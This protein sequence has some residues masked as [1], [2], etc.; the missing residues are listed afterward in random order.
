MKNTKNL[1]LGLLV[2]FLFGVS[3][4][5]QVPPTLV[6]PV[7]SDLC[8]SKVVDFD[9]SE[10]PNAVTYNLEVADN[11]QFNNLI[12]N[13]TGLTVTDTT[14][15]LP[16]WMQ[17]YYWR[18]TSVFPDNNKG[19]AN[20]WSFKTKRPPL[21]LLSP[22]NGVFCADS[23]VVFAWDRADAEF[24]TLQVSESPDF[25]TLVF[26]K[27]NII[28]TFFSVSLP[29]YSTTYYWKVAH[30]KGVCQ[31]NFSEVWHLITKL[32]PPALL[33]PVNNAMGGGLL[34]GLPFNV[35]L[36]WQKS[37]MDMHYDVQLSSFQNF[38]DTL[39]EATNILD[40]NFALTLPEDFN[41]SYYWRVRVKENDCYSYWS[42]PYTLKT[43]YSMVELVL[44]AAA[45][46]CVTMQNTLFKW[47]AKPEVAR[48][49]LQV[50]NT[51]TFDSLLIDTSSINGNEINLN[52]ELAVQTHY[53]RVRGDDNQNIGM[54]SDVNMF[55][56]TLRPPNIISPVNG[57]NGL[58]KN[59][60]FKWENFGSNATY[61]LKVYQE[62]SP[63]NYTVILDTLGLSINEFDFFVPN[64]NT[65]YR[66]QVRGFAGGCTGDWTIMNEF[67]TLIPSPFLLLP[68][69]KSVKTALNPIFKWSAVVDADNYDIEISTD[70]TFQ[71]KFLTDNHIE[72]LIW[73][74]AGT[75]Y[76]EKTKYFW[77]VR[78]RN[79]D[80]V[81]LWSVPFSF[82]TD[83]LPAAAPV[84]LEPANGAI[85][86]VL[87][88]TFKW[89]T[90]QRAV[91]YIL[92]VSTDNKFENIFITQETE[93]TELE[94]VG[95]DRY[96]NYWWKVQAIGA[97]N[98]G[99]ISEV[100]TFRTKDIAPDKSV[101]LVSPA[102]NATNLSLIVDF[103]WEE[104]ERALAY[105]LEI[106]KNSDFSAGSIVQTHPTVM[107]L[108]RIVSE[109]EY[110]TTYYWRVAAW[111]EDGQAGWSAVRQ[112]KTL[113]NTSVS[114]NDVNVNSHVVFPN[115]TSSIAN[116][117]INATSL[118]VGNMRILNLLGIEMKKVENVELNVGENIINVD[119]SNLPSGVYIYSIETS[120]GNTTGRLVIR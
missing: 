28:D 101:V 98:P 68:E 71:T 81:S 51:V 63:G 49:R 5:S 64:D 88:P 66:W 92:T 104:I 42:T 16:S 83:E 56:T 13:I 75:Q 11:P 41:K 105:R 86:V 96:T 109:L 22:I 17:E 1:M 27:N 94:V 25:E 74:K 57:I 87:S 90:S 79:E 21:E 55:V 26:N 50:S 76:L 119:I 39:A 99:L 47:V 8:V 40:T 44:P 35:N 78:A 46:N 112:F 116:I 70:S 106:A 34:S 108:H 48:Y 65:K 113:L 58:L 100:H 117:S 4:Y 73:T 45:A 9:W 67:R 82:T 84:L 18:A 15:E 118:S 52:L 89:E 31:S 36:V 29:K 61:E 69:D 120:T 30:K 3:A 59:I 111:N 33:L 10:V 114:S 91:S 24:Y 2:L 95:L 110:N 54:W 107:A 93:D 38:S 80:G 72:S 97:D 62:T 7:N 85:K 14:I 60:H 115:P 43:P 103:K 102:D 6:S 32:S 53:W 37:G 20:T 77:R 12:V 19:I 23:L